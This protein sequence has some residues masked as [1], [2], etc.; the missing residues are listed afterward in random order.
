MRVTFDPASQAWI[1]VWVDLFGRLN[2]AMRSVT[3]ARGRSEWREVRIRSAL[4]VAGR[5]VVNPLY[6]QQVTALDIVSTARFGSPQPAARQASLMLTAFGH[7]AGFAPEV[8]VAGFSVNASA[9]IYL[10][11]S[12]SGSPQGNGFVGPRNRGD[13]GRLALPSAPAPLESAE[14]EEGGLS[15]ANLSGAGRR[16]GV[17]LVVQTRQQRVLIF[18]R[19][20][21]AWIL[22]ESVDLAAEGD[23]QAPATIACYSRGHNGVSVPSSTLAYSAR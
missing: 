5:G 18:T 10:L 3:V 14:V 9:E 15:L 6:L 16:G 22:E 12:S 17:A 4:L 19:T 11:E 23:L 20:F 2:M 21:G 8:H 7:A 13:W 1:L